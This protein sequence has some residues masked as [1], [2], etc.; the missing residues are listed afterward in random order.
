MKTNQNQKTAYGPQ[1]KEIA[2]KATIVAALVAAFTLTLSTNANA[3]C[4]ADKLVGPGKMTLVQ[5]YLDEQKKCA[6]SCTPKCVK[7]LKDMVS[8]V[9]TNFKAAAYG[10][11]TWDSKEFKAKGLIKVTKAEDLGC[12]AKSDP[13][14]DKPKVD[15]P[16]AQ[17]TNVLPFNRHARPLVL[18]IEAKGYL[19]GLA[20]A[21]RDVIKNQLPSRLKR[22]EELGG[23]KAKRTL[24]AVTL[25]FDG[26]VDGCTTGAA[27]YDKLTNKTKWFLRQEKAM[28]DL[29]CSA[30][31]AVKEQIAKNVAEELVLN[32]AI[33]A[34]KE[35]ATKGET[36]V[37][38]LKAEVEKM[39]GKR[40]YKRLLKLLKRADR[41]RRKGWKKSL[42]KTEKALKPL[43]DKRDE[44][45]TAETELNAAKTK[46][47]DAEAKIVE[48]KKPLKQ[49][50]GWACKNDS[51]KKLLVAA[52]KFFNGS[53]VTKP[54][55][56]R[57]DVWLS[58][59]KKAKDPYMRALY[60][61]AAMSE[62]PDKKLAHLTTSLKDLFVDNGA[63]KSGKPEDGDPA[64]I[65]TPEGIRVGHRDGDGI[66]NLDGTVTKASAGD[67][68]MNLIAFASGGRIENLTLGVST[69][70]A[71]GFG[72]PDHIAGNGMVGAEF[73][74][75]Y[76]L[77]LSKNWRLGLS[78]GFGGFRVNGESSRRRDTDGNTGDTPEEDRWKWSV[79][80]GGRAG[81]K[82]TRNELL[83]SFGK[84]YVLPGLG[85]KAGAG[86]QT[87]R[88]KI[89]DVGLEIGYMH[90]MDSGVSSGTAWSV[91]RGNIPVQG[92]VSSLVFR[93]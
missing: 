10:A 60:T 64:A 40:K 46:V 71:A 9:E 29:G 47:A 52:V 30:D 55:F 82:I 24:K 2:M 27:K 14:T 38:D 31:A 1:T 72:G 90:M 25:A 6:S 57:A 26:A 59:A 93:F 84:L 78:A 36:K 61:W 70:L 63:V 76:L 13:K 45:K 7:D 87:N 8:D 80:A 34:Q 22:V 65:W 51:D 37:K 67:R 44:L 3:E 39:E 11:C 66:R 83:Y 17:S 68:W 81:Y 32:G 56:A 79:S 43:T 16:K 49:S 86:V 19:M 91:N 73:D 85:F 5:T 77:K 42:A 18:V 20:D 92:F 35:L 15:K 28:K 4:K 48:L 88:L 62:L 54:E 12:K 23:P 41:Y 74:V 33:K 21:F 58:K 89:V 50:F 69:S 75:E 53:N